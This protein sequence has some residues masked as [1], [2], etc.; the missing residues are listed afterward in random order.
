M[1]EKSIDESTKLSYWQMEKTIKVVNLQSEKL[2]VTLVPYVNNGR[3]MPIIH[4]FSDM[5]DPNIKNKLSLGDMLVSINDELL[6]S[7]NI[8]FNQQVELLRNG[9][10]PC[11]L[12]F[13]EKDY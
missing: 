5:V 12:G 8:S 11:R 1:N 7:K 9:T 3:E 13:I 4:S 10:R 2:Y 6:E